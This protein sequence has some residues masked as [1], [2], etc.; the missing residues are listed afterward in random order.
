MTKIA[1]VRNQGKPIGRVPEGA[2]GTTSRAHAETVGRAP[3]EAAI[4]AA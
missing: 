1:V 3:V 4:Q 2:S